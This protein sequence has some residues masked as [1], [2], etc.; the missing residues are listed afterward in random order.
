LF[1]NIKALRGAMVP[2][3]SKDLAEDWIVGLF[4]SLNGYEEG[5]YEETPTLG[6]I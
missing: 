2:R 4:Y 6:R 5:Y 3:S 1:G